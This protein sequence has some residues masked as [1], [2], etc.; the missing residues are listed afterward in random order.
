ML[1]FGWISSGAI[2]TYMVG[3]P[4]C[5]SETLKILITI[6]TILF[7]FKWF[8]RKKQIFPL[9]IT[10]FVF[11]FGWLY[12]NNVKTDRAIK[13]GAMVVMARIK[14]LRA[15]GRAGP[16]MYY[17]YYDLE[18]KYCGASQGLGVTAY[19]K[20]NINDIILIIYATECGGG[21][22]VYR[23]FPTQDKIEKYKTGVAYVDGKPLY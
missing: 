15:G 18:G 3:T 19:K 6:L 9:F 14:S 2:T 23:Y 12:L 22:R 13:R 20:L 1:L 17:E 4:I 11:I 16:S 7:I 8:V 21:S 10:L 5:G